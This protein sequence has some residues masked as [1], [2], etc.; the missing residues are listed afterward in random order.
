M[1]EMDV[2]QWTPAKIEFTN[3]D[4]RFFVNL[5]PQTD[6]SLGTGRVWNN[7]AKEFG[8]PL[9][10]QSLTRMP[11]GWRQLDSTE[12]HNEIRQIVLGEILKHYDRASD[13]I[14]DRYA[15]KQARYWATRNGV[16]V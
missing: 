14:W 5:L 15:E 9:S 2:T 8:Y 10:F 1:D 6:V 13:E 11:G 7:V 3:G 12:N 16:E 4:G